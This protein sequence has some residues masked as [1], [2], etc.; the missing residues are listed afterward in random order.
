[1][2]FTVTLTT[3]AMM[4][5]YAI[6]GFL[7][8]KGKLLKPDSISVLATLLLYLCSPFQTLYAMQQIEY[9]PYMLKYLGIALLLGLGLMGGS[10]GLLYY[11][12]QKK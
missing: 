7:M 8:I 6:P 1:M 4:L 3:F 5:L 2:S 12:K 9:S 10:L 11:K